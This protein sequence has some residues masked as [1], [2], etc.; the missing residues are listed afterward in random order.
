RAVREALLNDRAN[1][2]TVVAARLPIQDL[3][4]PDTGKMQDDFR[5]EYDELCPGRFRG[6]EQGE[7]DSPALTI[8][9]EWSFGYSRRQSAWTGLRSRSP[10]AG[11]H[12]A[13]F[14]RRRCGPWDRA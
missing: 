10:V 14:E 12:S 7:Q 5:S 1:H 11:F 8:C 6:N 13:G 3:L 9:P 4:P 2:G